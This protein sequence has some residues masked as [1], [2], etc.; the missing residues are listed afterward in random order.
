[1]T[2]SGGQTAHGPAAL[3]SCDRDFGFRQRSSWSMATYS[4]NAPCGRVIGGRPSW[5]Q[6]TGIGRECSVGSATG[7]L[8]SQRKKRRTLRLSA[9][10]APKTSCPGR[11]S[12]AAGPHAATRPLRTGQ[13]NDSPFH[14]SPAT[15]REGA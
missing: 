13:G 11:N 15:F 14:F 2:G 3:T 8:L 4:A 6:T 10:M 7:K 9:E 1:M 12:L 5:A